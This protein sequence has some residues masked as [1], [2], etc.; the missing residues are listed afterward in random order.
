MLKEV[1]KHPLYTLVHPFA[2]FSDLKFENKGRM[3]TAVVILILLILAAILQRQY[4][5]FV[6]NFN[7][8]RE[9]NSM[10]ELQFIVLPFVL[11][12]V[13]NWSVTT[14]MDGEGKFTEIVMA[15]AYS[16][17]PMVI[18]YFPMTWLSNYMTLEE[19]AFY[20]FFNMSAK[21]WFLWLLF[22]GTMTIHQYSVRKT[23]V[24]MGLTLVAMGI[25]IFLG[26][27]FFSLAQQ[28]IAFVYTITRELQFRV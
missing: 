16:L 21:I 15:T 13:S 10:D 2:G 20:H 17:L 9:L 25:I 8:P 7:N 6:V 11:W 28:V 12:C 4:A 3:K 19:S 24:T 26:L 27:L 22:I 18:I 1:I 23:L 5:G 14:L